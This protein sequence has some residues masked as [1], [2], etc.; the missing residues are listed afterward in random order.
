MRALIQRVGHAEVDIAGERVAAMRKL[1][2]GID[3]RSASRHP[4]WTGPDDL[5]IKSLLS[6]ITDSVSPDLE[7]AAV[8]D[9]VCKTANGGPALALN[10][11]GGDHPLVTERIFGRA[12]IPVDLDELAPDPHRELTATGFDT[13]DFAVSQVAAGRAVMAAGAILAAGDFVGRM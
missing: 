9:Q 4:D 2:A 1:P 5:K 3:Q 12:G 11:S 8:T 10:G 13:I 7:I 6:R